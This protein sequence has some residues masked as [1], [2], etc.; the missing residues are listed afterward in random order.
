MTVLGKPVPGAVRWV[1]AD[2]STI[3]PSLLRSGVRVDR[4]HDIALT[5]A[6][7]RAS[8]G[9][10]PPSAQPAAPP[11]RCLP[12][13]PVGRAAGHAV[14]AGRAGIDETREVLSG[15]VGGTRISCAGSPRTRT[16]PGSALLAAAESAGGLSA[17]EMRARGM[18]WRADVHDGLLEGLLG[19]RP[20]PGVRP[21]GWPTWPPRSPQR[22]AAARSTQILRLRC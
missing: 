4:C 11:G 12:G 13:R 1:W 21:P 19:R 5:E 7:L 22:S 18:P 8:G 20:G 16:R 14:R 3:Y 17:A 10:A 9:T 15:L 6:L 2:T